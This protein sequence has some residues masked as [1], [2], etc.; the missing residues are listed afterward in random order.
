MTLIR[1]LFIILTFLSIYSCE[2]KQEEI[3]PF[4]IDE[5]G[6]VIC[7]NTSTSITKGD[8]IVVQDETNPIVWKGTYTETT[9]N[10]NFTLPVGADGESEQYNF[11]FDKTAE[12]PKIQR[13]FKFYDGKNNDVSAVTEMDILEFYNHGWVKDTQFSG[14]ILYKDPHNKQ[15]F[16]RKFWIDFTENDQIV[17]NN[18]FSFFDDYFDGKFPIDIDM[19]KNG[20]VDY[21]MIAELKRDIGNTPQFNTYTIKLIST[22]ESD[23]LILSPIIKNGPFTVIYEAPFNS[24]N[25]RQYLNDVKNA[26]DVFYEFDAPYQNYNYF[27]NNNLTNR[28]FLINNKDDYYL[29][30][31]NFGDKKFYGWIKFKY[32]SENHTVEILETFLNPIETK[33]IYVD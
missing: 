22:N 29:I 16:S 10:I 23:N 15:F 2:S 26:L 8:N 9:I 33:H 3:P 21:K 6:S 5:N 17:E 31:M 14:L 20:S 32:D 1:N 19:D 18:T 13:A 11:V 24:E 25:K 27:L 7:N 30:K 12:C 4:K 28:D